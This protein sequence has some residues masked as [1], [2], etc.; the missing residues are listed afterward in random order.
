M[1]DDKKKSKVFIKKDKD[2]I[3]DNKS[4][5]FY[6][7]DRQ[8]SDS[9]I[10][11]ES[12]YDY[13]DS[14]DSIDYG[15]IRAEKEREE[16][17][18]LNVEEAILE[19]DINLEEVAQAFSNLSM[20]DEKIEKEEYVEK[21]SILDN[22]NDSL[23]KSIF[24]D[25]LY[26]QKSQNE[27]NS[28]LYNSLFEED[29]NLNNDSLEQT[30]E[31]K[32]VVQ[33]PDLSSTVVMGAIG[34]QLYENKYVEEDDDD[35]G[36]VD[37][38]EE[39]EKTYVKTNNSNVRSNILI[40][41]TEELD[42]EDGDYYY[43]KKGRRKKKKWFLKAFMKA[44]LLF[45]L[46]CAMISVYFAL[47]H[48]LFKIDYIDI[49]GNITNS[50]E[51]I[52]QKTGV[53]IGDNIFLV[54]KSSI[55]SN[56]KTIPTIEEVKVSRDLPNILRIE[57]K[58]KYV[59]SFINNNSGITT[60]DNYGKVKEINAKVQET[61]GVQLKG[62]TANGLAVGEDF[63]KDKAKKDMILDLISKDYFLDVESIDY[64][65]SEEIVM[66]IK[67]GLKVHFGDINDFSKKLDII[68]VLLEKIKT[69]N[70]NASEIILNVGENP[71]IVKK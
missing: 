15:K 63:T 60:I 16:L 17:Q 65:N 13:F 43:D 8:N 4:D 45:V 27:N 36:V 71:I 19:Q 39:P 66:E 40:D 55:E 33:N 24:E 61:R 1:S 2:I 58:E 38:Y 9:K 41:T 69:E 52:E 12:D 32:N 10:V 28:N 54:S 20:G 51:V 46:C 22:K 64:T 25:E 3:T 56:L 44:M 7:Y 70:I 35:Y 62:I 37:G 18:D 50:R 5:D 31:I 57:L 26:V 68:S 48:D 53:G 30:N 59:S 42:E 47:T 21:E 67:G 23:E 6:E 34:S 49:K 29:I 11:S 14:I